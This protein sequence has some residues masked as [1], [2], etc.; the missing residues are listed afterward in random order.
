MNNKQTV[1]SEKFLSQN[2]LFWPGQGPIVVKNERPNVFFGAGVATPNELSQA[3]PFDV[4]GFL[5]SGEFIK[6]EIPNSHVFLL[7]ADQHAWLANK[8]SEDTARRMADRQEKIFRRVISKFELSKW[9]IF[10]ASKLFPQA[11]PDS[12]ENLEARDVAHFFHQHNTEI[13]IG[14]K[15]AVKNNHHRTDEA[16]FDQNLGFDVKSIFIKPGATFD[17]SKSLESPYICT[18]P[19]K[20][21]LLS[22]DEKILDK[23]NSGSVPENQRRA[24]QNQLKRITMLF[25]RVVKPLPDKTPVNKKVKIIL[26]KIFN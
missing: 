24:V 4:L 6:R 26:D 13:K 20:R 2:P 8:I 3:I 12:Y 14:W 23:L 5:L 17:P 1:I 21:I 9:D 19:S 7:I 22:R 11:S 16:H 18:D 10:R 15:F 25:E